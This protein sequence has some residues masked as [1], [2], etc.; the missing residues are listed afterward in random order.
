MTK[1]N[2]VLALPDWGKYNRKNIID[3]KDPLICHINRFL[4]EKSIDI[5][6]FAYLTNNFNIKEP[7]TYVKAMVSD[8]TEEWIKA[9][10][11]KIDSLI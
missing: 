5:S 11:Q 6:L 2:K 8:Q 1:F 3:K 9:I 4:Q 7:K 10:E